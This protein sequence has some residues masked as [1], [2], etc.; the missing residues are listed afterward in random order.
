MSAPLFLL[1]APLFLALVLFPMRRWPQLAGIVAAGSAWLMAFVLI[2][3]VLG[4]QA[5]GATWE[6][7]GRTFTL[8]ESIQQLFVAVYFLSGII[9]LLSAF[10]VQGS[11]FVSLSMATLSPL[12]AALMV[13]PFAYGAVLLLIAVGGLAMLVQGSRAG[14]TLAAL[15]FLSLT[16]L[17]MPLLLSAGWMIES[18]QFQ[19]LDT[20]TL[21]IAVALLL[22]TASFP[23]QIWVAPVVGESSALT[24]S[25]VFGVGQLIIVAFGLNLLISEPFV[26]GNVEFQRVL[27]LSAAA[28]LILGAILAL[29]AR[30]FGQLLGYLLLLSMG[31]VIAV[32]GSGEAAVVEI[33]LSLL[34]LRAIGLIAAGAGLTL[35]RQ[36]ANTV[37]GGVSQFAA[38]KGLAWRAPLGTGLFVFGCV[39]LAGMPLTPGFAGT[40]PAVLVIGN[41]STWLAAI[42]VLT[43]ALGALGVLRRLIPLLAWPDD[44][45]TE[46][47]RSTESRREQIVS[48]L[49]LITFVIFTFFPRLILTFTG[50]LADLF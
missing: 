9:F 36:R 18:S 44:A 10:Y 35:I 42:V 41:H 21:L 15:R 17:A 1:T 31:T 34:I 28:T 46:E 11:V 39:S 32:I 45:V 19:F 4:P 24:P 2:G 3:Y 37:K 25:M 43:V 22:L 27:N 48:G 16:A 7:Y 23:F 33:T 38:N 26:F 49:I 8:T 50:N 13:E 47:R 12:S 20:F 29:T 5:S 40:W 6:V 14:S 30:S